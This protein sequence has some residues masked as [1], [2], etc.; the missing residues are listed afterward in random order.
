VIG[1]VELVRVDL[2]RQITEQFCGTSRVLDVVLFEQSLQE[3]IE[4]AVVHTKQGSVLSL[5]RDAKQAITDQVVKI[6]GGTRP[7]EKDRHGR[8][9]AV[10]VSLN[11][12]RYVKT[13]L[14]PVFGDLPVLSYQEI[15]EAIELN[16]V[17]WVTNPA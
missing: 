5:T 12:R 11:C 13:M 10:M 1:L 14:Q 6:L 3:R 8:P 2:H 17:G 4:Q 7:L 9:L 16:T 15:D